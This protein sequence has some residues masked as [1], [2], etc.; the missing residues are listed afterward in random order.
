M[1][2]QSGSRPNMRM[3]ILNAFVGFRR[4]NPK[5]GGEPYG[6]AMAATLG[7]VFVRTMPINSFHQLR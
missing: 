6:G 5:M 2:R 3:G 7:R 4:D 1:L